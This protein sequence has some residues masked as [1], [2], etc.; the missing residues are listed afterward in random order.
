VNTP[1]SDWYAF[2]TA[3]TGNAWSAGG[4]V[5]YRTACE[6]AVPATGAANQDSDSGQRW[7]NG[8]YQT[9]NYNHVMPPNG[10]SCA[11][12][13]SSGNLDANTHGCTPPTSYHKGGVNLAFCD[14]SVRFVRDTVAAGVW[15]AVGARKDG[16]AF[17]GSDL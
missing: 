14:G 10:R 7:F 17:S 16:V 2:P 5:N 6:G 12:V 4:S 3:P 11:E 13:G 1:L 9:G 8:N 15:S